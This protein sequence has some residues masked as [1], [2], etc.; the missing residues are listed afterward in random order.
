MSGDVTQ[1]LSRLREG[2][3]G[4]LDRLVPLLYDELRRMAHSRLQNERVGHTLGTT[5]LVHEVYLKLLQQHSLKAQDRV[6]FFAIAGN[7]MRR[8]LVDYARGRRRQKRGGGQAPVPFEDVEQFLSDREAEEVLALDDS[9]QQLGEVNPR[10][11]KVVAYRF[12]AGLTV[13]EIAELLE[14]ST[15]TVQ[16]DWI[17]ARAW[18]RKEVSRDLALGE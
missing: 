18:L 13:E 8:I 17:A 7:T 6:Q 9:L 11:A 4:A 3:A 15:K 16:R 2:D 1:W 12:Y 14:V 10:G 5:A